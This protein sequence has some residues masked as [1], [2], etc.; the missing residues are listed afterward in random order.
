MWEFYAGDHAE[1][2]GRYVGA[3]VF[4]NKKDDAAVVEL[5]GTRF[6][7]LL[8]ALRPD[9]RTPKCRI[10]R[11]WA[12]GGDY[13]RRQANGIWDC[14]R[15]SPNA[16]TTPSMSRKWPQTMGTEF[17]GDFEHYVRAVREAPRDAHYDGMESET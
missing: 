12:A 3:I 15:R 14:R 13:S 2:A 9:R 16:E 1:A 11:W 17:C 4:I 6:R 10:C 5:G 7:F 8:S